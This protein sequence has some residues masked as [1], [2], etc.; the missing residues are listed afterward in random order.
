MESKEKEDGYVLVRTDKVLA[1]HVPNLSAVK[2]KVKAGWQKAEKRKKAGAI[3]EKVAE[4]MKK[5]VPLS[6][7]KGEAL[8]KTTSAPVKVDEA[9]PNAPREILAPLFD[10]GKG[11]TAVVALANGEAVLRV[12]NII[13]GSEK[14]A[15]QRKTAMKEKLE[16]EWLGL[17]LE[18]LDRALRVEFPVKID[19]K[20]LERMTAEN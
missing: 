19:Q 11:E 2:D 9:Q 13:P 14:E 4:Q 16:K 7:V 17:H 3:L 10:L 5:G 8:Q 20:T 6:E 18:E 15:A 12:K 1:S